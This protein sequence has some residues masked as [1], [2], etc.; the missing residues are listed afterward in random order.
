MTTLSRGWLGHGVRALCVMALVG[1]TALV[2]GGVA[3]AG[4]DIPARCQPIAGLAGGTGP[5][6]GAKSWAV[7]DERSGKV[8]A[9][10]RGHSPM[11]PASTQKVFTALA[12]LPHLD[13][14]ASYVARQQDVEAEGTQVGLV[15]GRRYTVGQLWHGLIL[16][17]GNDAASALANAFGGWRKA[18]GAINAEAARIHASGTHVKN[19]S[20]LDE[21]GQVSCAVDLAN[22]LRNAVTQP[23]LRELLG[24]RR[25]NFPMVVETSVGEGGSRRITRE[26]RM[27]VIETIDPMVRDRFPG[28]VGGKTG[29]TTNAGRTYVGIARRRGVSLIISL[30]DFP[31]NT[32]DEAATLFNWGFAHAAGLPGAGQLPAADP[33]SPAAIA[34]EPPVTGAAGPVAQ[35][36]DDDAAAV[37]G[38]LRGLR[39]GDPGFSALSDVRRGM[40][41]ILVAESALAILVCAILVHVLGRRRR[42][43]T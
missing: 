27:G 36:G 40:A 6:I 19:P 30:M 26:T 43:R 29:Y 1:L 24:T 39:V 22:A 10:C 28:I 14:R 16:R 11:P 18:V 15:E 23:R 41:M 4:E 42:P 37:G 20:G 21:P 25:A 12:L 7:V 38:S 17:S 31:G 35:A 33:V 9:E 2:G 5:D 32:E 3:A 8:L 13:P 34:A